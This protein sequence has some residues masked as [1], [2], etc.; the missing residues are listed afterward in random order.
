MKLLPNSLLT[1]PQ[2]TNYGAEVYVTYDNKVWGNLSPLFAETDAEKELI[3]KKDKEL[4]EFTKVKKAFV[5]T[6]PLE[7]T[8]MVLDEKVSGV[9]TYNNNDTFVYLRTN[10]IIATRLGYRYEIV[11]APAD[12]AIFIGVHPDF[13]GLVALHLGFAQVFMNLHLQTFKLFATLYPTIDLSG[14]RIFI[15]PYICGRHYY[16]SEERFDYL[17]RTGV[18]QSRFSDYV[19]KKDRKYYVDFV[20]AAKEELSEKFGITTFYEPGLCTYELAQ[21]DKLFSHKYSKEHKESRE[22]VFNVIVVTS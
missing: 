10:G 1:Y 20:K 3:K 7:P 19:V 15:T 13:E 2:V 12:C 6:T 4:L 17:N 11:F 8:L 5:A 18:L 16:I 9:L 14:F 21:K 22:G